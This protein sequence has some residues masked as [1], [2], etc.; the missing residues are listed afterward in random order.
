MQLC[1]P[2]SHGNQGQAGSAHLLSYPARYK[3]AG[4]LGERLVTADTVSKHC[5]TRAAALTS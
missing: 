3:A 5:R 4:E 2:G 1:V